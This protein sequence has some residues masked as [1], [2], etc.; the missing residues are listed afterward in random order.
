MSHTRQDGKSTVSEPLQTVTEFNVH[1]G[2]GD[3]DAAMRLVA[4]DCVLTVHVSEDLV[5]HAGQWVGADQIRLALATARHHY[6]Y[7]LY[8]PLIMGTEGNTVRV[9]VEFIG[10]HRPSGEP[11]SMMFR[12][13]IVVEN[14]HITRCDEYHDRSKLEAYLKLIQMY[15]SDAAGGG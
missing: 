8:R 9:R 7:V 15:S 11:M 13:V 10:K 2:R 12:Q 6:D 3:L 1:W 5:E 4:D 14:G